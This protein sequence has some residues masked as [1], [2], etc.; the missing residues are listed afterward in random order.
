MLV[1]TFA[2]S[3]SW[4]VDINRTKEMKR[5]DKN[6]E[7]Q[8][9]GSLVDPSGLSLAPYGCALNYIELLS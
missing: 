3:C 8:Y 6:I 5:L 1:R 2:V 7:E 4:T 9:Q